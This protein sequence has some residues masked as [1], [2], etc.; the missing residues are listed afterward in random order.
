MDSG[1]YA[2]YTGLLARTQALDLA[3]NNLA[4]AG[5]SGFR[6]GRETFRGVL[7]DA[8][9]DSAS[10]VGN[11]INSYGVLGASSLSNAQGQIT[12]T[13]N[14]LDLAIQGTGY[15]AVKT[16][17]GVRYTRDGSFQVSSAGEL[18]TKAGAAVLNA[19]G[20]PITVPSGAVKVGDDGSI[21][22]ATA[23]GSAVV[24][25]VAIVDLGANGA[26]EAEGANIYKAADDVTPAV[27]AGSSIQAG[28]L[29]GANQDVIHGTMQLMLMQRQAEMMQKAITVFNND[30]DKTATEEI[31]RV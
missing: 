27:A 30:F 18:T 10:Q 5:T 9:G 24:G 13:G 11:S 26:V 21:S 14:P 19:S 16:A 15:F 20:S 28:A 2:V 22:V 23:E 25:K 8:T 29:E 1:L 12:P 6:A 31:S 17:N 3:A 4:N 7:A